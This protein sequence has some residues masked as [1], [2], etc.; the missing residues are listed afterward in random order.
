L[1]WSSHVRDETKALY[2]GRDRGGGGG[3]FFE[4][5]FK[6]GYF[7]ARFKGNSWGRTRISVIDLGPVVSKEFNGG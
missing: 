3:I 5:L 7:K 1:E 2:R 6:I 4:S